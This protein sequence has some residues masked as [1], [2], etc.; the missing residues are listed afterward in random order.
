M[1]R[2]EERVNA[3]IRANHEGIVQI[4]TP[5]EAL[6]GGAVGL[7]GEKYGSKVRVVHF[8]ASVELCGGTHAKRT[9]DLGF[10]KITAELGIANRIRRIEMLTAK[11]AVKWVSKELTILD[12]IADLL[13]TTRSEAKNKV[14][15]LLNDIKVKE[16]ELQEILQKQAALTALELLNKVQKINNID[17]LMAEIKSTDMQGLR[18]MLDS[19]RNKLENAIII[20]YTKDAARMNL[21]V[22]VS[23]SLADLNLHAATLAKSICEKSG[24]RAELAQGGGDIPADLDAR[25]KAIV[26]KI[27]TYKG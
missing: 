1:Q 22:Y 10:F 14:L 19:L 27:R 26:Q 21:L 24:G 8:G 4:K 13:K 18:V 11:E 2:V 6:A 3:E 17:F 12:E 23:Q 5:E 20:L 9:G 7:F 15:S 16:K 25:L